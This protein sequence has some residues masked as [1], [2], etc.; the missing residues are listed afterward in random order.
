MHTYAFSYAGQFYH[1]AFSSTTSTVELPVV[2]CNIVSTRSMN[3]SYREVTFAVDIEQNESKCVLHI[4][5]SAYS[6]QV[7]VAGMHTVRC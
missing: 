6:L 3:E 7:Q 4:S 5:L 1:A 2:H